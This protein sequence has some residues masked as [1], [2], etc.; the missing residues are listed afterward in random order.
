M[1]LIL[2]GVL[3]G[4]LLTDSWEFLFQ[5]SHT[6]ILSLYSS[7]ALYFIFTLFTF[8]CTL[9][10]NYFFFVSHV[11]YS[12]SVHFNHQKFCCLLTVQL[13][14]MKG[15]V[16]VNL[17]VVLPSTFISFIACFCQN[18][19]FN[20]SHSL[21]SQP[22]PVICIHMASISTNQVLHT[23]ITDILHSLLISYLR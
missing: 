5:G 18:I 12:V 13:I 8:I 6:S 9:F 15:W 1:H 2:L 10:C 16:V 21:I 17:L 4:A 20:P 23:L 22:W 19:I 14:H 3:T 7:I 11:N